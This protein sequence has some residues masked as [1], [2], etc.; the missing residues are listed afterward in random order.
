MQKENPSWYVWIILAIA[1]FFLIFNTGCLPVDT[2]RQIVE[3]VLVDDESDAR[4][5]LID[6]IADVVREELDD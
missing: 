1:G 5:R 3:D 6:A 2:V 4:D